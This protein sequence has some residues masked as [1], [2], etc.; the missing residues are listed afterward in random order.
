M[1]L[2]AIMF[3]MYGAHL[4]NIMTMLPMQT[5]WQSKLPLLKLQHK[6]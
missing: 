1:L 2:E 6:P 3:Y 5:P 4:C